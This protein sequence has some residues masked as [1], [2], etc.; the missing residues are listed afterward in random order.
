MLAL[1]AAAY[2][3]FPGRA[4]IAAQPNPIVDAGS[5]P[6]AQAQS[7]AAENWN[8]LAIPLNA[9]STITNAQSLADSIPGT[10]QVLKWNVAGQSFQFYFPDIG[11][12]D[13]F[14][15]QTGEAFFV[16]V[17]NTAAN[18]FTVVGDVPPQSGQPGAVEFNLTGNS[19]ACKW[20]HISI[21]LDQ[22]ANFSDAATL[23]TN[24]GNVEQLL[25]WDPAAQNFKFY[26]PEISFGDNFNVATGYPY[27]VCMK[28]SK[29]WP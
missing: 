24:I 2:L 28:T 8:E 17:N 6:A 12:G 3:A 5:A 4:D 25:S 14:S 9:S 21:P 10:V 22:G 29:N 26:F 20:N 13:N 23:S 27:F 19:T 16:Q 7:P 1:A 18:T 15:V 11:F